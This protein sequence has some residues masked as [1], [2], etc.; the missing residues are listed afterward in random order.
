MAQPHQIVRHL[1]L[2]VPELFFVGQ[3]LPFTPAAH[4]KMCTN[5]SNSIGRIAVKTDYRS[6]KEVFLFF[7]DLQVNHIAGD[8]MRYKDNQLVDTSHSHAFGSDILNGYMLY[9]PVLLA[10][11][12]AIH[13]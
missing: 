7:S 4:R 10:I 6:L 3:I 9:N 13:C 5:R 8:G 12:H 11:G 1:F 2:L